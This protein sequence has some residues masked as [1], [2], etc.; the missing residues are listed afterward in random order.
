MY[1]A[2]T[3]FIPVEMTDWLKDNR[4][5]VNAQWI[6]RDAAKADFLSV[7]GN[8]EFE[9]KA[10]FVQPDLY[11]AELEKAGIAHALVSPIP[12]L[13]LYE[14]PAAV[15]GE[16]ANVYNDALAKWAKSRENRLTALATLPM[17]DPHRAGLELQRAMSQGLL[18]AIV[19]SSWNGKML[20]DDEFAPFWEAAD[21]L[22]AIVFIHPLL[23]QDPRLARRMMPNL[24][25]V[26]WET[27]LCAVDLVLS[28]MLDRYPR[29]KILLAHGG[30][31]FPYQI[32]RLQRG[33][34]QWKAVS[35]SLQAS[36]AEYAAR[37][38]YDSVLW[39]PDG[40][41]YLIGLAG[42]NRV[43]QGTDFPFDLCEWPPGFEGTAGFRSLL[44]FDSRP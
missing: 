37:F 28:G 1:D 38:W 9:L 6:K 19:G 25:G 39:N 30:G 33:Y 21:A 40:L 18:G 12:Q 2:H 36:P 42:E 3:H 27:T 10:A 29:A 41:R 15:T 8:W 24:I 43:V 4:K 20:S 44:G 23:H 17:N 5:R 34:G 31:Y 32:G 11:L 35:A 26:P 7:N 22:K 13:F 14:F 16:A